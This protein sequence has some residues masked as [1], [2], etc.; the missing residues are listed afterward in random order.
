M[1]KREKEDEKERD[2]EEEDERERRDGKQGLSRLC[3]RR[4]NFF[5]HHFYILEFV[6]SSSSSFSFFFFWEAKLTH[7]ISTRN[8]EHQPLDTLQALF[9][10]TIQQQFIPRRLNSNYTGKGKTKGTKM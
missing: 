6:P 8:K 3:V 5:S 9:A 1:R 7:R 10:L 4:E 2:G